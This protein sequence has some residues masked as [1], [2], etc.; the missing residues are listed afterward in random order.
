MLPPVLPL[1]GGGLVWP[2]TT[3]LPSD[4]PGGLSVSLRHSALFHSARRPSPLSLTHYHDQE[5][6]TVYQGDKAGWELFSVIPMKYISD[7]LTD[8]CVPDLLWPDSL[9]C[10]AK[11]EFWHLIILHIILSPTTLYGVNLKKSSLKFTN[12]SASRVG[13]G[14]RQVYGRDWLRRSPVR[15]PGGGDSESSEPDFS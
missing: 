11:Y 4:W 3:W 14:W 15:Q 7:C 10:P 5:H 13:P 8:I 9:I 12:I 1:C 2:R 6:N